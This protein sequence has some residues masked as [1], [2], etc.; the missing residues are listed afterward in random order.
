MLSLVT[1]TFQAT[2]TRTGLMIAIFIMSIEC[3]S[4]VGSVLMFPPRLANRTCAE[5]VID[6]DGS[7]INKSQ[8]FYYEH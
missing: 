6:R 2:G 3:V 4:N 1:D 7:N 5:P 8:C